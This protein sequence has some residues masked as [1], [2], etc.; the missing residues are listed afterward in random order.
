MKRFS[1]LIYWLLISCVFCSAQSI[2]V[3]TYNIRLET[4][5]DTGNLWQQRILPI[6]SLITYNDFDIFG[7]QEALPG[8][9][10]DLQAK[11]SAYSNYGKGRDDGKNAGEHASIFFKTTKFILKDSG[12]FWLSSTPDVP[13]KGWDARCCNRICSWVKLKSKRSGRDLFVFNVHFDH[14]G[15]TARRESALLILRRIRAIA[16][17]QPVI[18]TGDFNTGRGTEPYNILENSEE[19]HDSRYDVKYAYEPN[20]SFNGFGKIQQDTVVIDHIFLSRH[21]KATR[22]GLL[23]DTYSGKFPSDHF[24]VS[25][26]ITERPISKAPRIPKLE[27]P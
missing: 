2:N 9:L 20:G 5:S 19:L 10:A 12:D 17:A 23:T 25:V 14:E 15:I 16:G 22:W 27:K 13:G 7:V 11:L 4:S 3:A 8:Q 6:A 21:F 1:M 24:P 26:T 18:L